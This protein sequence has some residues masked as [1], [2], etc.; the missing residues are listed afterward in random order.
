[1][2]SQQK[3]QLPARGLIMP[4]DIMTRWRVSVSKETD[5]SLRRFMAQRG[6]KKSDLSKFVEDAVK[7]RIFDQTLTEVRDKF[8]DMPDDKL[9]TLVD[10]ACSS[11]RTPDASSPF[12]QTPS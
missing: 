1:M 9:Q 12:A 11:R 10:S 8:A 5:I 7:W 4:A 3:A 2:L 6:L